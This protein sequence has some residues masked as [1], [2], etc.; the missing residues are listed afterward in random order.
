MTLQRQLCYKIQTEIEMLQ[1]DLAE[2][3]EEYVPV[4]SLVDVKRG[5]GTWRDVEV[6]SIHKL[7]AA[8]DFVGRTTNGKLH[9][10]NWKDVVSVSQPKSPPQD[11]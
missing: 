4:G 10:F 6:T 11:S 2:A 8:G 1:N 3:V 5:K 7:E 9:H